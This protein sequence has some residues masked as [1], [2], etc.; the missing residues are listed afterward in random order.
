MLY[1]LGL[2]ILVP[3]LNVF[4]S[5]SPLYL[6]AEKAAYFGINDTI[7]HL[8]PME[9]LDWC[10]RATGPRDH[11]VVGDK[12]E[13]LVQA[14]QY[15]FV[16]QKNETSSTLCTMTPTASQVNLL[17][18]LVDEDYWYQYFIDR[19]YPVV[20]FF[21]ARWGGNVVAP[22]D[23][24]MRSYGETG[25]DPAS[26]VVPQE[27]RDGDSISFMFTHQEFVFHTDKN[28]EITYVD[29]HKSGL[30]PIDENVELTFTYATQWI[31]DG[32]QR[33]PIS[34]VETI[35][36]KPSLLHKFG[37][38]FAMS[39]CLC[40]IFCMAL[41]YSLEEN[42]HFL[43]WCQIVRRDFERPAYCAAA[44]GFLVST[45]VGLGVSLVFFVIIGHPGIFFGNLAAGMLLKSFQVMW[46]F[47]YHPFFLSQAIVTFPMGLLD[48]LLSILA[49]YLP[50]LMPAT[51]TD[52]L[53]RQSA[54]EEPRVHDVM[55][56]FVS[57]APFSCMCIIFKCAM[58]HFFLPGA[59]DTEWALF[60][61]CALSL[62]LAVG[63]ISIFVAEFLCRRKVCSWRMF[64]AQFLSGLYLF[65]FISYNYEHLFRHLDS[66]SAT[67]HCLLLLLGCFGLGLFQA[68]GA[69]LFSEMARGFLRKRYPLYGLERA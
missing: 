40:V 2:W 55:L 39:W 41:V 33:Q 17:K 11:A 48:T 47:P 10:L 30:R 54:Y 57:G 51:K 4:A 24:W 49:L 52:Q 15:R 36:D 67:G 68:S 20:S 16:P 37:V 44:F 42:R 35:F 64:G 5:A 50:S 26:S 53:V 58:A 29:L 7:P 69:Y 56:I 63:M 59:N 65:A 13:S 31:D 3:R 38:P 23:P 14:E 19:K 18:M 32:Q 66:R 43:V 12:E 27:L 62:L 8:I 60:T 34:L 9:D 22:L 6:W 28:L 21:G 1:S 61:V 25:P 45:G 46:T